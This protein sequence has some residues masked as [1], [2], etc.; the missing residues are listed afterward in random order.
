MENSGVRGRG[1][2]DR[3][4][5]WEAHIRVQ[6]R[7][8]LTIAE[9]CRRQCLSKTQFYY[10]K[11]KISASGKKGASVALVQ[12]GKIRV[13]KRDAF[14]FRLRLRSGYEIEVREDFSE[15]ALCRLLTVMEGEGCM[16]G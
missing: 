12:V 13:S 7:S 14:S 2:R 5:F 6:A 11:N 4:S 9:Y 10:W 8:G 16:G 3:R 15:S 1:I